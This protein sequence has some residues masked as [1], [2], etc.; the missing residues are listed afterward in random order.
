M[1]LRFHSE[2]SEL[3][4]EFTLQLFIVIQKKTDQAATRSRTDD[5]LVFSS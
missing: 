5:V 4:N 2:R 1:A 3:A